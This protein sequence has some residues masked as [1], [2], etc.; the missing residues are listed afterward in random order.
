MSTAIAA[1]T[2]Q[3]YSGYSSSDGSALPTAPA[4][5]APPTLAMANVANVSEA[6][7]R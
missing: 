4:A 5:S 1:L 6:G 2:A 7:S 3:K